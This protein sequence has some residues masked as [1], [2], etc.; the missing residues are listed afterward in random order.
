MKINWIKKLSISVVFNNGEPRTI[1]FKKVFKHLEIEKDSPAKI[2]INPAEFA[3]VELV[4]NSSLYAIL[5]PDYIEFKQKNHLSRV[6]S[7]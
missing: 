1:D 6:F 2:L 4:N 3:K 7:G 5:Q